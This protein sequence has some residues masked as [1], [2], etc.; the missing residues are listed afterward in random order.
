MEYLFAGSAKAAILRGDPFP[1]GL[2]IQAWISFD[3]CE[4]LTRF[5]KVLMVPGWLSLKGCP[6]L[7]ALPDKL[8]IGGSLILDECLIRHDCVCIT[9][10]LPE[11]IFAA[12]PGM[13]LSALFSHRL[14][15]GRPIMDLKIKSLKWGKNDL[16]FITLEDSPLRH[17]S[18][19]DGA[20]RET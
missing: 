10:K 13:P 7:E 6:N 2:L 4:E 11:I 12:L 8:T 18:F 17:L 15:K 20:E 1:D 9:C 19:P 14:L 16:L 3:D 5:P